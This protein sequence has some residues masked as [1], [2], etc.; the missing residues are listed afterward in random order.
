M[1]FLSVKK[2]R[3]LQTIVSQRLKQKWTSVVS[4]QFIFLTMVYGTTLTK[5]VF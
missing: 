4:A 3:Y 5:F 2:R 1:D